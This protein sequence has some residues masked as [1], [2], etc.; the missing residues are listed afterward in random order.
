M[1][2]EADAVCRPGNE[3]KNRTDFYRTLNDYCRQSSV[4]GYSG[5]D[6]VIKDFELNNR[7]LKSCR[8]TTTLPVS[9]T[10]IRTL[11]M[12]TIFSQAIESVISLCFINLKGIDLKEIRVIARLQN[13]V[14]VV[15]GIKLIVCAANAHDTLTQRSLHSVQ[16]PQY[17]ST[18]VAPT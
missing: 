17:C 3:G 13:M 14:K 6:F 12:C 11:C 1:V 7:W 8:V 18:H 9:G 15:A 5:A 10:P 2:D 4:D 16:I